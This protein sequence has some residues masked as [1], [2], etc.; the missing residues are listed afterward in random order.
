MLQGWSLFWHMSLSLIAVWCVIPVGAWVAA[1][2]RSTR[3][4]AHVTIQSSGTLLLVLASAIAFLGVSGAHLASWHACCAL[5]AL[6]LVVFVVPHLGYDATDAKAVFWHK[7]L[8]RVAWLWAAATSL[9][10]LH[11]VWPNC[12]AVTSGGLLGLSL[13][14]VT[15]WR[16]LP[17]A[18]VPVRVSRRRPGQ[19]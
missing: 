13:L 10:G 9:L 12:M 16:C 5:I 14:L 3:V 7:W 17:P 8:G 19:T 2:G 1:A 18:N 4:E 11:M 15:W 6:V